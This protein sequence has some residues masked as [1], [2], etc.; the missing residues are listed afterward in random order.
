[1]GLFSRR[2]DPS[3]WHCRLL[4]DR[5]IWPDPCRCANKSQRNVPD[6]CHQYHRLR[7]RGYAGDNI[8]DIPAIW[9]HIRHCENTVLRRCRTVYDI[10][11][12]GF[13]IPRTDNVSFE[14]GRIELCATTLPLRRYAAAA[15]VSQHR[16]VW[17]G[18]GFHQL[19]QR[20]RFSRGAS[21][22]PGGHR[23]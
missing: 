23:P 14:S 3:Y 21:R 8:L 4:P 7:D 9:H 6:C 10:V 1:M 20:N 13:A 12:R 17:R 2:S 11:R 15:L 5:S 16:H 18:L 22:G 19:Y